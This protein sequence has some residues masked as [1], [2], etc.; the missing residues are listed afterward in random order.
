MF[1]MNCENCGE[2]IK[3]L[4]LA[5]VQVV[6]CIE[7][8]KIVVVKNVVVSNENESNK[9]R[10]SLKN[11]LRTTKTKFRM[12]KYDNTNL[13]KK[14]ITDDRLTKHLVR[15]DYRLKI[16]DDLFGQINFD[17]N[18]RLARILNISYEGAGIEFS[19]RGDLPTNDSEAQL[20]LLLPGY[21]EI[22]SIPAKVSWTKNPGKNTINPSVT[23]G[24]HFRDIDLYTHKCLSGFIWGNQTQNINTRQC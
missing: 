22:L 3:S 20:Q 11:F 17:Q 15:D 24:L 13:M 9:N 16:S 1:Q 6:E 19:E 10:T 14:N 8:A 5:E 7:C 18:K 12:K 2:L 4:R 23:M 21:D